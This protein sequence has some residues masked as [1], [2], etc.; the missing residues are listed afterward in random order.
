MLNVNV[1]FNIRIYAQQKVLLSLHYVGLSKQL[2]VCW[3]AQLLESM[4]FP[5]YRFLAANQ[6]YLFAICQI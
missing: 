3:Y 5:S 1:S 4:K 6:L 2:T